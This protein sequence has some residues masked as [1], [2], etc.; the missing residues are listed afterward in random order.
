MRLLDLLFPPRADEYALRAVSPDTFLAFVMPR[1]V[2][3][4]RP[5]TVTL[6]PFNEP[7]VR[8]A[9]HEAK[10][11]GSDKAFIYLGTALADY[12]RG[13]DDIK[14]P[15][16]IPIPLGSGRRAERGFNQVE[17][18]AKRTGAE[19]GIP[20][21]TELLVRTHETASQV[22]LPREAR[23]QNMQGAFAATR[24]ADPAFTY[25]LIDD[26]IT[27]G[28]TLQAAVDALTAAGATHLIPLALAH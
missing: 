18:I 21:D 9:I 27:T 23:K 10:Y 22:S 25:I 3:E 19:L 16:I 2:P 7:V 1:V 13:A 6:L 11:H 5:E 24:H 8:A 17:E 12:L 28:A 26:V 15:V 14:R 20:L 4:T